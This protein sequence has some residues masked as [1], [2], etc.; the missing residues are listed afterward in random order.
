MLYTGIHVLYT[1][2]TYVIHACIT[3]MLQKLYTIA[4]YITG[5]YT[6][7]SQSKMWLYTCYTLV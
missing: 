5:V 6:S 2:Y 3:M 4:V 1:Q 7:V